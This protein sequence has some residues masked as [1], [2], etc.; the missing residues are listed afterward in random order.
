MNTNKHPLK[1]SIIVSDLSTSGSGRWGGAVRPFL[2]GKALQRIGYQVKIFGL[3][4]GSQ[5]P[6]FST[7]IPI[8]YVPCEYHSGIIS[9][10][11]ELLNQIDGDILYAIKPKTTSYGLAIIK[12]LTSGRPLILDIDDWEMS[13]HGGDNWRFGFK[14]I[15]FIKEIIKED[16]ALRYPDHP[17][18][19][20]W[21]EKFISY[22]DAVTTHNTFL[23]KRFGGTY[24]P[25]GK[26]LELFNPAKFDPL[27][28]KTKYGLEKYRVLMFPGAP[29]PYKGLEDLLEAMDILQWEDLRLVIVG[30]SPY[31]D[32]DQYLQQKWSKWIISMEP[33]PFEQMPE[34]I[35]CADVMVIPQ[36][37][38]PE[39]IAQFP[40]KLTD[41]MAMAKPIL[42][43]RVGDIPEV[44]QETGYL[45]EPQSPEDLAQGL[46][47]I[48]N[49]YDTA[50]EMGLRAR[51]RYFRYYS[52]E[53]MMFMLDKIIT[54]L[55]IK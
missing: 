15:K 11:K 44:L 50:I 6:K 31:D 20:R 9:A 19:L 26:D 18:Y 52:L 43:T 25:Q 12:K 27:T 30:G 42:A 28:C 37:Q 16:G 4:F 8:V 2:L 34:I 32:Y 51:E 1:I 21:L 38:T 17:L 54:S 48:F 13:W 46:K 10:S 41:A 7:D 39:T 55:P 29:R 24:I 36:R 3:G 49:D 40:L 53:Q 23:Q 33:Q 35:S 22:A 14:P 47:T 5:T 45:V